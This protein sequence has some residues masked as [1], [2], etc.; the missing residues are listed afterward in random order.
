MQMIQRTTKV[1]NSWL[2]LS[3]SNQ[4]LQSVATEKVTVVR[5]DPGI[6]S[7]S[8]WNLDSCNIIIIAPACRPLLGTPHS[9]SRPSDDWE[10]HTLNCSAAYAYLNF[11]G[12]FSS[13]W[14]TTTHIFARIRKK[15]S[16]YI[17]YTLHFI[18]SFLF[19]IILVL[20]IKSIT[21]NNYRIDLGAVIVWILCSCIIRSYI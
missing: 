21:K 17:S 20:A 10:S 16:F 15:S 12:E 18:C 1:A 8:P 6:R 7:P 5:M 14:F 13:M 9:V 4:W 11:R 19:N 2:M 3:C